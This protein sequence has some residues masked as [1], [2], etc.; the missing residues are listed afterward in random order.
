M[1]AVVGIVRS[2]LRALLAAHKRNKYVIAHIRS[3]TCSHASVM[4]AHGQRIRDMVP[5]SHGWGDEIPSNI[6][7]GWTT[8]EAVSYLECG[9][10]LN[11]DAEIKSHWSAGYP[12]LVLYD[13]SKRYWYFGLFGAQQPNNSHSFSATTVAHFC[14][15]VCDTGPLENHAFIG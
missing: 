4:R 13:E 10:V 11:L 2:G 6:C 12:V 7:Y 15:V 14:G 5:F 3:W 9:Y 8:W 1:N